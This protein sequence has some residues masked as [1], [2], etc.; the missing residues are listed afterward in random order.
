M[1]GAASVDIVVKVFDQA[2]KALKDIS[3]ANGELGKGSKSTALMLKGLG[4]AALGVTAAVAAFAVAAKAAFEIGKQGAAIKQ[5]GESFEFLTQKV[6][7]SADLLDQLRTASRGTISDMA[8]MSSTAT[9]LAGAQGDLATELAK[10]TP[11]LLNIAKAAQKLNPALGSTTFLYDSLATG[12]KRA[13]PMI[14]D[15]LGLTIRIGAANEAFAKTLGK[16]VAALTA[17]EQKQALLNE[18]LRAGAVLIEQAGGT[19]ES[20]TDAYGFLE[21]EIANLTDTLKTNVH[22]AVLPWVNA[23]GKAIDK[24]GKWLDSL[25]KSEEETRIATEMT[26]MFGDS[27]AVFYGIT[28]AGMIGGRHAAKKYNEELEKHRI[29]V[30]ESIA[31]SDEAAAQRR[32][33]IGLW[34][35]MT[36]EVGE[37]HAAILELNNAKRD[38]KQME[39]DIAAA[40]GE[41]ATALE[42][43]TALQDELTEAVEVAKDEYGLLSDEYQSSLAVLRLVT[44]AIEGTTTAEK[45]STKATDDLEGATRR[46]GKTALITAHS[47]IR[48]YTISIA[49]SKIVMG[50][51]MDGV[52][53]YMGLIMAGLTPALQATML[54]TD[55]LGDAVGSLIQQYEDGDAPINNYIGSTESSTRATDNMTS[56]QTTLQTSLSSTASKYNQVAKSAREAL[57]AQGATIIPDLGI[58]SAGGNLRSAKVGEEWEE[59]HGEWRS[60]AGGR[61]EEIHA[62]D[63]I[64]DMVT[65]HGFDPANPQQWGL[66]FLASQA[67]GGGTAF[68]R[69]ES[70][71]N[72][73]SEVVANPGAKHGA[74]FIVPQGYQNDNYMMGVSSGERVSVT[75]AHSTSGGGGMV[76]QNLYLTGVQTDSALFE[77]IVRVARQRGR[78]FARV[79]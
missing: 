7:A 2:S 17:D 51:A 41:G 50:L 5:T 1:A 44:E 33:D 55:F 45:D 25:Q 23:A 36:K 16:T 12:V 15:N 37:N 19:T 29:I 10:A 70:I 8:L 24:S 72:A 57:A 14:L 34:Q 62:E 77:A 69:Q 40:R 54:V 38:S 47:A 31:L 30:I 35:D 63:V 27:M 73:L 3:K 39:L 79:M 42:T 68:T 4:K 58:V 9:L 46:L 75:P 18:T 26:R 64:R 13:S 59:V 74:N 49:E 43:Q 76:I 6:G 52:D 61:F 60:G 65:R 22:E 53:D 67:G 28:T 56:A 20:A 48:P 71:T 32:Q 21:A 66:D 11:Q 78:D